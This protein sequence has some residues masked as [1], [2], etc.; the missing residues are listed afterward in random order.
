MSW[1]KLTFEPF[2]K[3]MKSGERGRAAMDAKV[4]KLLTVYKNKDLI[5]VAKT[6]DWSELAEKAKA[7]TRRFRNDFYTKKPK[8]E[9][10]EAA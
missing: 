9:S 3:E 6:G 1:H 10:M 2:Q 8:Y 5:A 7:Q 4:N